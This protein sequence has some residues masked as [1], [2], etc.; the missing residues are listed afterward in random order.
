[1]SDNG[2]ISR[3]QRA[4]R[5]DPETSDLDWKVGMALSTYADQYTDPARGYIAGHHA[6]PGL[7]RLAQ[8]AHVARRNVPG[9]LAGLIDRKLIEL[10]ENNVKRPGRNYEYT[11]LSLESVTVDTKE[12][13]TGD[14]GE[15][16]TVDTK[17]SVT[18]DTQG[19]A[20][21][22]SSVSAQPVRDQADAP[23]APPA[24]MTDEKKDQ[25]QAAKPPESPAAGYLPMARA[26]RPARQPCQCPEKHRGRC[27]ERQYA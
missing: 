25:E 18:G 21:D 22:V 2:F 14:T 16:V 24:A 15:S 10:G 19:I 1:M 17:E 12:S 9:V 5:D 26:P 7:T 23:A 11:L 20:Q 27:K 13:V 6:R 3:W 4:L 8:A